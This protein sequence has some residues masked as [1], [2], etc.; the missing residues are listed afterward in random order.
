MVIVQ[1]QL[2]VLKM[3]VLT[4][5]ILQSMNKILSMSMIKL[6]HYDSEDEANSANEEE[7]DESDE[8]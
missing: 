3:C 7:A 1:K 4:Y 6:L 5:N 8:E 2:L